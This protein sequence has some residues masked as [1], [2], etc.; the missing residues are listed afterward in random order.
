MKT[1]TQGFT[2]TQTTV[3]LVRAFKRIQCKRGRMIQHA[4]DVIWNEITLR[5]EAAKLAVGP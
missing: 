3:E 1:Q 5:V 2:L 4:A